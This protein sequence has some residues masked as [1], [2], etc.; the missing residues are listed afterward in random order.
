MRILEEVKGQASADM[1]L[2]LA[3]VIAVAVLVAGVL[4]TTAGKGQKLAEDN[5]Q[6]ALKDIKEIS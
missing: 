5:T 3:A 6:K 2:V 1:L 4:Q